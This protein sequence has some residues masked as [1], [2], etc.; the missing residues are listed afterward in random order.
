VL[1]S[2][3]AY[4]AEGIHFKEERLPARQLL[5]AYQA[6]EARE[7]EDEFQEAV[8]ALRVQQ[9]GIPLTKMLRPQLNLQLQHLREEHDE[10]QSFTKQQRHLQE[11]THLE[12]R[13]KREQRHRVAQQDVFNA[14]EKNLVQAEDP[15]AN[16]TVA[17]VL[18]VR[19]C[20]ACV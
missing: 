4:S 2:V 1:I 10:R 6:T 16:I 7:E 14:W 12:R 3:G 18:A 11:N 5:A 9:R 15:E 17:A 20:L 8:R 19:G 13:L